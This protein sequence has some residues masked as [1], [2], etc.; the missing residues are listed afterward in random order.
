M[1][2]VLTLDGKEKALF[3]ECLAVGAEYIGIGTNEAYWAEL[4]T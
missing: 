1:V 4:H 2:D 3:E